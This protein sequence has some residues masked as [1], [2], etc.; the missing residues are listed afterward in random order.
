MTRFRIVHLLVAAPLFSAPVLAGGCVSTTLQ[1]AANH[2]AR[3]DAA[4]GAGSDPAAVLLPDAALDRSAP[5]AVTEVAQ[6]REP[7]GTRENPFVGRGV[8]RD[9]AEGALVIQ[10][11]SI[12]GFMGAMTMSYPV[13]DDVEV[14]NLEAG[15]AVT[16]RI[17][18]PESGGYRIFGVEAIAPEGETD[19]TAPP[20]PASP[21]A[22]P[23]LQR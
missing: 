20:E 1:I 23:G 2:P 8:V 11:E 22:N 3:P 10:H 4:A 12:P 9:V 17:E 16:F 14:G 7:D 21:S 6:A 19:G 13:A 5:P 15:D 18:L